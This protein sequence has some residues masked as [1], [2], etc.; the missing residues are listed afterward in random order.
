VSSTGRGPRLGGADDFFATPAWS[1]RRLLESW[2][3]PGGL[4]LEPGAGNG[5]IIRAVNEVRQDVSWLAVELRPEEKGALLATGAR[6][7][8]DDFLGPSMFHAVDDD[9][10]VVLGN[11]PFKDAQEFIDRARQLCPRAE[12]MLLLRLN[13]VGSEE[14]AEFMRRCPPDLRTLP[15]RPSFTSSGKTDSIEYAWFGWPPGQ[16][17]CGTFRVLA[18]TSLDERKGRGIYGIYLPG[19]QES[20][21]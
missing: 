18:S 21:V 15:N 7:I 9:I 4:W 3:P 1:V 6:V 8:C 19:S 17:E 13:Y 5:A 20:L 2:S 10:R 12:I 11:P 16:R 14:R